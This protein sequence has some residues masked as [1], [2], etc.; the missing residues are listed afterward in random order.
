MKHVHIVGVCGTFMG[1]VAKLAAAEGFRVSGC[2]SQVYPPMSDQL[3]SSG[4][5]LRDGYLP[6]HL[7]EL[8]PDEVIIGNA[9]SRGNP[10]VEAILD[11]GLPYESGPAWLAREV[12]RDRWV[13]AVAGTHGKT[14]TSSLLAWILDQEGLD[15]G[16]LIGGVPENFG[17]SARPGSGECFVVEADEYDTAFFDKRSKFVHYHPRTL[18]L[19]NLEF[20][21]ADI[22]D[23]LGAIQR[24]FHH[25]V[26]TVPGRGRIIVNG[27]DANL[28]AVLDMGC[29]TPVERVGPPDSDCDWTVTYPASAAGA[30]RLRGP[31]GLDLQYDWRVPAAYN[32]W[33]AAG[34]LAAARHAGVAP[35][36]AAP[37]IQ[38][39][40]SVK[41]RL[42]QVA[43]VDGVTIIDDFAHHPTAV[44]QTL[45]A[46]REPGRSGRLICV[47]EP[48]SNTMRRGVQRRAL[49][50]ALALADQAIVF[51][52]PE[53]QWDAAELRSDSIVVLDDTQEIIEHLSRQCRPG[54]RI[55]IMSNGGFEN[56][57]RRLVEHLRG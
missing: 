4:V 29:W 50:R 22:F 38:S 43:S 47:F 32:A 48:R 11:R 16:F 28:Q 10:L 55:V 35:A 56:L 15:P 14:T 21:H 25:L 40:R 13:L 42:E 44:G 18:V 24:Q 19:N 57:T 8:Q 1:G 49:G 30:F 5:E 39:F 27:R 6:E 54:D 20:D 7:D 41:R 34:A 52:S 2:D 33:N 37:A 51:Q 23:D 9:L 12:L 17:V 3:A 36:D 31:E 53:M 46:L 26:R 45:E